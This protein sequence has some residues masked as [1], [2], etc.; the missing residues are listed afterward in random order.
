MAPSS[1]TP[2]LVELIAL[3]RD[4]WE[5]GDA[6]LRKATFMMD[7]AVRENIFDKGWRL[8]LTLL[9]IS[10]ATTDRKL[11]GPINGPGVE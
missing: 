8:R 11:D 4:D 3:V 10:Q 6:I 9:A 7:T 2:L 1:L 5:N